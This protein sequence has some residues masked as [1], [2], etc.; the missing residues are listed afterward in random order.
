LSEATRVEWVPL[1]SVPRMIDAGEIWNGG[2][3]VALSRVLMK[4]RA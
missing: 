2:S 3:L 1:E 4:G